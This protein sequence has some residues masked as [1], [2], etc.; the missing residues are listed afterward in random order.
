MLKRFKKVLSKRLL[1]WGILSIL[2]STLLIFFKTSFF[3]GFRIQFLFWGLINS[4]IALIGL[5][6]EDKK[7]NI[8]EKDY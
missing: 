5:I 8:S 2:I 1:L 6:K 3:I 4:F 7:F